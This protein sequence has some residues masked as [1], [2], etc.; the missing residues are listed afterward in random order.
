MGNTIKSFPYQKV[1]SAVVHSAQQQWSGC[2]NGA[3]SGAGKTG[4]LAYQGTACAERLGLWWG[5]SKWLNYVCVN[6]CFVQ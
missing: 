1:Q 3:V 6:L 2:A 5:A 4:K